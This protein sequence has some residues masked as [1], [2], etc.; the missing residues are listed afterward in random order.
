MRG[1]NIKKFISVL[2]SAVFV[3]SCVG[4][5]LFG[6]NEDAFDPNAANDN[7]ITCMIWDRGDLPDGVGFDDNALA[8]WIR[9]QVQKETGVEVHFTSV[10][11]ENTNETVQKMI[12]DGT[13]PDI[14]FSYSK[15]LFGNLAGKGQISD[16]TEAYKN[17]GKDISKNIGELQ[18]MGEYNDVQAAIIKHRG[19]VMPRHVA[20]VRRDWCEALGMEEPTNKEELEE[21]LYAV[22]EKNPGGVDGVIPWAMGGTINSEKAYNSFVGSFVSDISPR[23][24]YLYSERFIVLTDEANIGLK[25]LNRYY[26]DGL[27]TLDFAADKD[28]TKFMEAIKSGKVGFFVDDNTSPFSLF[29][30]LNGNEGK[31]CF[32]PVMCFDL[33]NG[34]YRNVCEPS[35]GLY[36]MVPNRSKN[37]VDAVMKYLNWLADPENAVDVAYTPDHKLTDKGAPRNLTSDELKEN[38]YPGTPHDYCIVNNLFFENDREKQISTWA[39]GSDWAD[40]EW[41]E[42]FYDVCTTD[43]YFFL[44]SNVSL[45]PEAKY[46]TK[47]DQMVVEYAYNLICCNPADFNEIKLDEEN[48]LMKNGLGEILDERAAYFDSGAI[49]Y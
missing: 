13:A 1:S 48:K 7:Y 9:N 25:E 29:E 19:F 27:I 11:R 21:Y 12:D 31:I 5:G 35:T 30:V 2:I 32:D 10:K 4:C 16:L 14:V 47:L 49:K 38:K 6:E 43:N 40:Q 24:S 18:K 36:I 33:P 41:Y 15:A 8:V 20:Y 42:K 39:Y 23:N 3:A 17:Y 22:K 28:N 34:G 37:K 26:N 46:Q 45:E 44:T